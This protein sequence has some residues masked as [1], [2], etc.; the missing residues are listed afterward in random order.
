MSV[1]AVRLPTHTDPYTHAKDRT[2]HRSPSIIAT[3]LP[4]YPENAYLHMI[5]PVLGHDL[6][7]G[8]S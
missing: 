3:H 7:M 2:T 1:L 8:G 6:H 4:S 5:R